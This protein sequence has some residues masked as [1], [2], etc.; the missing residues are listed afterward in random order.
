MWRRCSDFRGRTHSITHAPVL[1]LLRTF[2]TNFKYRMGKEF[3]SDEDK[4]PD[5]ANGKKELAACR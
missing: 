4:T 1:L 5:T 3:E 2:D